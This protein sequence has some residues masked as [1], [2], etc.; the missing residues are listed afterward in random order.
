[1][2]KKQKKLYTEKLIEILG[3]EESGQIT[4]T[5]VV[6]ILENLN[7]ITEKGKIKFLDKL[8]NMNL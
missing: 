6:E 4:F 5:D 3:Q 2:K 7:L 1:M 8:S